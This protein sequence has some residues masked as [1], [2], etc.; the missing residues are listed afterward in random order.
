MPQTFATNLF[1]E[2]FQV[3]PFIVIGDSTSHG[4]KVISAGATMLVKG[5]PVARLGDLTMCPLCKIPSPIV[6]GDPT[7]LVEGIPAARQGDK[8]GCGASLL[9]SQSVAGSA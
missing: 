4:G 6:S 5:K 8:T 3:K 7:F 9:P 2:E 1:I